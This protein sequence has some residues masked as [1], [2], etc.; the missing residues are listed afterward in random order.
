MF[1]T[2]VKHLFL[3]CSISHRSG[4]I[5]NTFQLKI[6]MFKLLD[7]LWLLC[8]LCNTI[9]HA[10]MVCHYITQAL[11]KTYI[12]PSIGSRLC[13]SVITGNYTTA[14]GV[15][16]IVFY[17]NVIKITQAL[18][19]ALIAKFALQLFILQSITCWSQK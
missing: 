16:L 4:T 2:T 11:F 7:L 6:N 1:H 14:H 15:I 3:T 17:C 13:I 10:H 12:Y 18:N 5:D 9:Q 8:A 19:S